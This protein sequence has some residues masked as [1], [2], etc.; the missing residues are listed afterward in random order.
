MKYSVYQHW[1]SLKVCIVGRSY[2]PEFYHFIKNDRVRA[3]MERIARETEE[4]YQKLINLLESFNVDVLRPTVS[5]DYTDCLYNGKILPPP[6][7]PRD[8]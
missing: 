2:S 7:T 4:D 5:E 1:D 3:V 8:Y 6:M